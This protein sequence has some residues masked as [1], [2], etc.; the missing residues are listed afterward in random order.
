M[1]QRTLP[2]HRPRT[3]ETGG[4]ENVNI[5]GQGPV[6][7]NCDTYQAAV[8]NCMLPKGFKLIQEDTVFKEIQQRFINLENHKKQ[9]AR[10]DKEKKREEEKL[11]A[12]N[13]KLK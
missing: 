7:V 11:A 5:A 2:A 12:K 6:Y 9:Q 10:L 1:L 8:L 4:M 13:E 3:L